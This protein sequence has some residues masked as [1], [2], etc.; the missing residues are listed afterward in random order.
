MGT[1]LIKC[2]CANKYQDKQYGKGQRV[3]NLTIKEKGQDSTYA[4]CTNCGKEK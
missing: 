4:R 2:N 3:A 1:I